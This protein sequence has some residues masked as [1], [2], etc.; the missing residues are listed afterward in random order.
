MNQRAKLI[1]NTIERCILI[2]TFLTIIFL[3]NLSIA[4]QK[5]L[6]LH[7][8]FNFKIMISYEL[9]L[10]FI[11]FN[12]IQIPVFKFCMRHIL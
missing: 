2:L 4:Y 10:F 3:V 9:P 7:V 1:L 5:E 6:I 11:G 12:F 8:L